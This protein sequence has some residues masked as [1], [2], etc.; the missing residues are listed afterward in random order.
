MKPRGRTYKRA[1]DTMKK[2]K[3]NGTVTF[4]RKSKYWYFKVLREDL[5]TGEK[6][7][8]HMHYMGKLLG[9]Y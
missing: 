1:K 6:E 2:E 9:T 7:L 8:M 3:I 5:H 4:A